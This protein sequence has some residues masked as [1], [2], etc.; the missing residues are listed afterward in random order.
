M[1]TGDPLVVVAA[2]LKVILDDYF[3]EEDKKRPKGQ[4]DGFKNRNTSFYGVK[5]YLADQSGISVSKM[6]QI[7]E[8]KIEHTSLKVADALLSGMERPDLMRHIRVVPN[9][10]WSQEKWLAWKQSCDSEE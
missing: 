9:P 1:S 6:Y 4:T 5:Q 3:R 7:T 8:G 2:D 10:R